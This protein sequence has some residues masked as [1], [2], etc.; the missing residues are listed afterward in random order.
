[1]RD[2]GYWK[3]VMYWH[4]EEKLVNEAFKG[5]LE[6]E[7]A[8]ERVQ[9]E[10]AEKNKYFNESVTAQKNRVG[11]SQK[12]FIHFIEPLSEK[13]RRKF[14]EDRIISVDRFDDEL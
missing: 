7:N 11:L 5:K 8:R 14:W 6:L 9:E 1:M 4:T 2:S 12:F 13:E 10:K 3:Q